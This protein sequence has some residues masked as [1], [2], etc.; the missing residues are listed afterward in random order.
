MW[1]LVCSHYSDEDD[2]NDDPDG[3]NGDD[4]GGVGDNDDDGNNVQQW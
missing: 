4:D 1:Y 3:K 2:G